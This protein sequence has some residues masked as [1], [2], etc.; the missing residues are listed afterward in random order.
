MKNFLIEK[1]REDGVVIVTADERV[2]A[3][4]LERRYE[5]LE[6]ARV[7]NH[8]A[9]IKENLRKARIALQQEPTPANVKALEDATAALRDP[10]MPRVTTQIR[11]AMAQLREKEIPPL[12]GGIVR[13]LVPLVKEKKTELLRLEQAHTLEA[14]GR[15]LRNQALL[16][17]LAA[18]EHEV[19][20]VLGSAVHSFTSAPAWWL[21]ALGETD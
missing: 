18:A 19:C 13:R 3:L 21:R 17:L 9:T 8:P 7:R 11:G 6:E 14:Y 1:L 4:E 15:E 20:V 2:K 10:E 12:F 5:E 16:D